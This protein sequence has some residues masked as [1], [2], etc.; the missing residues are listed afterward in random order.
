MDFR[1]LGPVQVSR[2]GEGVHIGSLMQ[3][4]LL[5]LLLVHA[6]SPVSVERVIDVLWP[7][8]PPPSAP[9]GVHAY[10]SRLRAVL[11]DAVEIES[12]PHG[13][14]LAIQGHDLDARRF[15]Q[16]VGAA[17]PRLD[18]D[19]AGAAAGLAEALA[20]WR[21][22]AYGEF[23]HEEFAR[24]EAVRLD[25]LWLAA[26]EDAFAARLACGDAGVVGE[27]EAFAAAN[28]LRE[29]PHGQLMTAL[30]QAGRQGE[31]LEVFARLRARLADELGLEPSPALSQLEV[32]ILRQAPEVMPPTGDAGPRPTGPRRID[33]GV[34][35]AEPQQPGNLPEPVTSFV[36]RRDETE[37]VSG[38]LDR[39][40]LV[41]L[42]GP[43]G[44]GKTRLALHA[45]AVAADRHPDAVWWCELAPADADAVGHTVADV[46]GV[47]PQAGRS[48]PE[49]IV[50]ALAGKQLL[51]VLDNCEHVADAAAQLVE[52]VLRSCPRVTTLATSREPLAVEGEQVWQVPP[53]ALPAGH[54][55]V[56]APAVRL[57]ADRAAAHRAGFDVE[58][59]TAEAVVEICR[60]LDGLP[61]AIELAAALV[62]ALEPSEIARR[63]GQRFG[64][65]THGSRTDP[66]HRS[67]AAVVEWS[68]GLL[69]ADE[70]RL[71]DRLAVFA[72][73]FTLAAAE[74]VC[75][76]GQ[77]PWDRVAGL[78]AGLVSRSMVEVDRRATP[79]RYRLLETLRH[80]AAERLA[81]RGDAPALSARHA[82]WFVDLAEH[83][84]ADVRGPG[85]IAAVALLEA[86]LANLRA[87]HRWAVAH[88]DADTALRLAAA[89]YVF[90]IWRL[91]DEVFD[92]AEEA[93]E[94]PA[95]V[96]HRLQ[97]TVCGVA[98]V[99]ISNRGE[100]DRTR[101]FAERALAAAAESGDPQPFP[102]LVALWSAAIYEGRL[103]DHRTHTRE[104][105]AVA[106]RDGDA[107]ERLWAR[108]HG[109]MSLV[110]GGDRDAGFKAAQAGLAAADEL[111]NPGQRGWARYVLAEAHGD[112]DPE[113]ALTLLEEALAL[114]E[115]VGDRF[116]EG[117]A[118]VGIA[119]LR[120]RHH[121]PR[122]ALSAFP[123][124]IG[125][126]RRA[127]DWTHQWTT[128]RNLVPLLVRLDAD[129]PAA[130]LFGAQQS[131]DTGT[132]GADAVR[133][134]EAGE[135]LTARLG[136][137]RFE[138]LL[139][140]GRA[141][142][143]PDAVD[144]A[145][146]SIADLLEN[147]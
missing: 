111:G 63:L 28:P 18:D 11:G 132:F 64:L 22:P 8:E 146:D 121:P 78:L 60:Q 48:V 110:Y 98:A 93:A 117:V 40:R 6:G 79:T 46:L 96:G 31:A 73:G 53:L 56:E 9:K 141:L 23:A 25:E 114:A 71:F 127:G 12:G 57:F 77:L 13:Y 51:L 89:L 42:T 147:R 92:W 75:A 47:Q 116:L 52:Q 128:L 61:L 123:D 145:L 107:Y 14:Q 144:L 55:G 44:V 139:D 109:V 131:A 72:G 137:T 41:T 76:D 19:P 49:A 104:A 102:A 45:A 113:R 106:R 82:A 122:D 33:T 26:T 97:P 7:G 16:L 24:P 32:E 88:G 81:E 90:A 39:G 67:L 101:E 69:D 120:A 142:D 99:G 80:Y 125:H 86:E 38:L 17:R 70:Q 124:V 135:T 37:V 30:A 1:V 10:V 83:A 130:R 27:L 34:R 143:G 87:V 62:P 119:S 118:R 15:E 5:A 65:L 136:T 3:R 43:G 108:V 103:A 68:Y 58:E 21:G 138:A 74:G 105:L 94:L 36:G 20:L 133:L 112:D 91:R 35:G 54:A 134:A 29:R 2:D 84:D 129:E 126:W 50:G 140:E 115:P 95:A 59:A 100:L 85:E 4:R 66:R